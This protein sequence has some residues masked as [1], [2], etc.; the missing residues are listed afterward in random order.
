[1]SK[2]P[3]TQRIPF[4]NPTNFEVGQTKI[5]KGTPFTITAITRV[6]D[7]TYKVYG[8]PC[9]Q[10]M[11][12]EQYKEYQAQRESGRLNIYLAGSHILDVT[13]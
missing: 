8:L 4:S 5:V 11:K 3:Y 12:I 9:S 7:K 13:L 1:M 2:Q 10:P 6:T